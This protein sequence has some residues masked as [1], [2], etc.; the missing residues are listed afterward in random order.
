MSYWLFAN[1]AESVRQS[2]KNRPFKRSIICGIALA[3]PVSL[4]H[5]LY[6]QSRLTANLDEFNNWKRLRKRYRRPGQLR[7]RAPEDLWRKYP[8]CQS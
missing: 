8:F 6:L 2:Q 7:P 5:L 3:F 1:V 4:C